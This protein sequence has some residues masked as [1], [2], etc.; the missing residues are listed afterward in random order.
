MEPVEILGFTDAFSER[1][2]ADDALVG[3]KPHERTLVDAV[4]RQFELLGRGDLDAFLAEMH[5]DVKLE[6]AAPHKFPWMRTAH[7]VTALREAIAHN[8]S[9]L[10]GQQPE[11]V[12][13]VAQGNVVIVIGRERGRIRQ[14]GEPYDVYFTYRFTF[15]DGKLWRILE[16]AAE[17][18]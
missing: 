1:F 2:E 18:A 12:S 6:I 3:S 11:L 4:R 5:A 10:E 9:V 14:S 13:I 17:R 7:G 15:R 8:F 16:I